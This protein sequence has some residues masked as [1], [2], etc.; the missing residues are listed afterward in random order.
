M[1]KALA[2]GNKVDIRSMKTVSDE[3]RKSI[4]LSQVIDIVNSTQLIITMP[5]Q[6]TKIVPL[7]LEQRYECTYYTAKGLFQGEF[8]VK[9]RYK[10]G[11][12]P[13]ILLEIRT[14]LK[15]VQRR[16]YY[17]YDC[18]LPMK[19][20]FASL[21]ERIPRE[22]LH[23]LEWKDGV[24]LDLSGGGIR[25]VVTDSVPKDCMLQFN[26]VLE[27][28][29]QYKAFYI[30]GEVISSKVKNNNVRLRE[31]RAQFVKLSEPERD[32]IIS[33]IFEQ[34]RKKLNSN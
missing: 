25:F 9:E 6:G 32:Q 3:T 10:E 24:I 17:R 16:E 1:L 2:I 30:Y 34:E 15:K 26:L 31:C 4:Y 13:V 18:T 28:Q 14:P 21:D 19:Y 29:E 20:R 23:E 27:I 12:L 11:N 33:Y 7:D 22:N 8:V 5:S